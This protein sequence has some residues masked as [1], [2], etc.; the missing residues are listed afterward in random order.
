MA[1]MARPPT[2]IVLSESERQ[3]LEALVRAPRVQRRYSDRARIILKASAGQSTADIAAEMDLR[4]ATVSKWRVRFESEGMEGL[5]DDYRP[6]RPPRADSREDLRGKLLELLDE[7]PPEGYARWNGKL[8]A[9]RI[10]IKPDL[11]WKELRT[12]GISLERRRSWCVSTDP[13]FASKAADIVGLYL[14][15]PENAVVLSI[16]EKPCIQ[17]LERQ[18]GWLKMP[19]GRA[20]T[21]FAHEYRRHETTNLFAALN[22]AT[23]QVLGK[24]FAKKTRDEFLKFLDVAVAQN[25][26]KELHLVLDNL[27]VHKLAENH[28]WRT[29]NPNV[30]FHF[31]PTHASWI[32]QIEAW[33]S[34]L[35]RQ[36]LKGA[37]FTNV[38]SLI[39][40]IE[41]FIVSHNQEAMPF[42]W[43]KIR[44]SQK[45]PQS[46]YADLIN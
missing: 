41:K 27:S 43:T 3:Q 10:G 30:H 44:V 32:N 13:E 15:P 6:G 45:T 20:M 16:D 2:A 21:G 38:K 42:V 37:S 25:P 18:Q 22:V 4:S 36:A 9:K 5:Y 12:L 39:A 7:E 46:K 29:K 14:G 26:G 31:T 33:F 28:P 8:L 34:I 40:A 19:D 1:S 24:C 35:S 23:G 11:V 17:A